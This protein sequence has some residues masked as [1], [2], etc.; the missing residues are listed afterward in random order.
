MVQGA[1]APCE[2]DPRY[3]L[4]L[5]M[6][7]F[8]HSLLFCSGWADDPEASRRQGIELAQ[9]TLQVAGDDPLA[10]ARVSVAL[11]NFDQDVEPIIGLVDRS[12]ALNPGR[13]QAG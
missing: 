9:R 1:D 13:L 3:G 2:R 11:I 8:C 10:L 5:A 6:A 12:L 4:A 7:G